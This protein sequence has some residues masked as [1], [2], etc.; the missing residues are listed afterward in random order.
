VAV[1]TCLFAVLFVDAC[2]AK[3]CEEDPTGSGKIDGNVLKSGFKRIL[4]AYTLGHVDTPGIT[5]IFAFDKAVT[6]CEMQEEGWDERVSNGTLMLEIGLAG[7]G[8]GRYPVSTAAEPAEGEASVAVKYKTV[9]GLA[10]SAAS[11]GSVTID[12]IR[13]GEA[14]GSFDV[15]FADGHVSGTLSTAACV[16]GGEP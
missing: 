6:C 13:D 15:T 3:K 9:D 14:V 1:A 4:A 12:S 7:T 16:E 2:T 5:V 11:E 8:K 10:E